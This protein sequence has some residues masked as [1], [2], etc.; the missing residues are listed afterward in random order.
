MY[1]SILLL[2][3]CGTAEKNVLWSLIFWVSEFFFFLVR[4]LGLLG[5]RIGPYQCLLTI[6]DKENNGEIALPIRAANNFEFTIHVLE[7]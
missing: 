1:L 4:L 3:G 2:S 6:Q 7:R 5:R